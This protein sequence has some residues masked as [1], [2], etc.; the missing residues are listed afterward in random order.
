MFAGSRSVKL[1][2]HRVNIFL[3]IIGYLNYLSE[4]VC[5]QPQHASNGQSPPPNGHRKLSSCRWRTWLAQLNGVAASTH[6]TLIIDNYFES[7]EIIEVKAV[8]TGSAIKSS[9]NHRENIC[10]STTQVAH[11]ILAKW[12]ANVLSLSLSSFYSP[13]VIFFK[14]SAICKN[15]I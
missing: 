4:F 11:M 2:L 7:R 8:R 9:I 6:W 12:W 5:F 10:F 1:I 3:H 15:H 13:F 14:N